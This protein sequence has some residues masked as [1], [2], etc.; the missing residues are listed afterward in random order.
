MNNSEIIEVLPI[1]TVVKVAGSIDAAITAISIRGLEFS[2]AYECQWATDSL[3]SQWVDEL[4]VNP[5]EKDINKIKIGFK[6]KV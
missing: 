1:G 2:I 4:M 3:Q 5:N 6:Q